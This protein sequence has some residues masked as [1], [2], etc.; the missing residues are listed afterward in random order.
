MVRVLLTG[1]AGN[2]G[3]AVTRLVAGAGYDIRMAD[4]VPPPPDVAT[5]GEFA[6]CDTRTPVGASAMVP[7]SQPSRT[8]RSAKGRKKHTTE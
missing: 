7:Q 6:R 4:T 5:L 8:R 1:T 3:Q 2:T